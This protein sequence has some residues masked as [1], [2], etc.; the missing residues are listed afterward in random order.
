MFLTAFI[1]LVTTLLGGGAFV[2]MGQRGLDNLEH[3]LSFGGAFIIGMCFLHLV[4][5]A[6]GATEL[7]GIFV[8][9][10]FLLQGGLEY[11]SQGIEHGHFHAHEHDEHCEDP[12]LKIRLPWMALISL[13]LHA[14]LES[15]PVVGGHEHHAGHVHGPLALDLVDWGLMIGLVL[16]KVPV[17]MVLMAMMVESHVP[18]RQAWL[19]L[20]FFGLAPLAGMVIFEGLLH[21][22]PSELMVSFPGMMQAMVVG[23]LLHIG[24]TVLFEAGEG[25]AFNKKKFLATCLGL[26]LGLLAFA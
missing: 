9:I 7:A 20:V 23:I 17:S 18:R 8:L 12:N 1:F 25:H 6:F 15:M 19:V 3:I 14:A 16:H 21:W 10:G 24:T 26:G 4:P 11:M 13:S 5:E 22:L 2:L